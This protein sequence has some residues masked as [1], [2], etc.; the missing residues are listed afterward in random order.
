MRKPGRPKQQTV[1]T[2]EQIVTTTQ[3]LIIEQQALPSIRQI[4]Q[5]LAVDP[6]AIY[7]YFKNKRQLI[8]FIEKQLALQ[9]ERYTSNN[10]LSETVQLTKFVQYYLVSLAPYQCIIRDIRSTSDNPLWLA[11]NAKIALWLAPKFSAQQRK[12]YWCYLNGLLLF[13][14]NSD[15]TKPVLLALK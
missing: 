3:R 6:M 1:L 11:F 10:Q 4:A 13:T 15:L 8:Y 5:K 7:Y 9:L 14:E 12:H 2:V